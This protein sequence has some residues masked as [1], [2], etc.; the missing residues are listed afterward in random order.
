MLSFSSNH[1]VIREMWN[2]PNHRYHFTPISLAKHLKSDQHQ[3]SDP[4]M[5]Q[6]IGCSAPGA[7]GLESLDASPWWKSGRCLL[8]CSL[9]FNSSFMVFSVV[10]KFFLFEC[11]KSVSIFSFM[12]CIFYV[13]WGKS[14]LLLQS[15]RGVFLR[16]LPKVFLFTFKSSFFLKKKIL[17]VLWGEGSIPW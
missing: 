15:H 5:G 7:E 1:G 2:Y 9:S 6:R 16:F 11:S 12:V 10:Q 4:V 14:F 3:I 17:T 8:V 13:F